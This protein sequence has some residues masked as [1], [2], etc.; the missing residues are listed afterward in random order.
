MSQ[1]PARK[2]RPAARPVSQA[3]ARP[4]NRARARP[5]TSRLV[6]ALLVLLA[7]AGLYGIAGLNRA[8]EATAVR[9]AGAVGQ[10]AVT[11]ALLGCPG[12]GSGPVTGGSFAEASAPASTGSGHVTLTVPVPSAEGQLA[13]PAVTTPQ[14]G[15]LTVKAIKTAPAQPKKAA[16]LP[17]MAGGRV[18]T[19]RAAGGVFVSAAGANAQG[20]DV[21][22]LGGGG[23]PTA[24]CQAPGSDFWFVGPE[25]TTTQTQ[26]YLMNPDGAPA[27]ARVDV[28]TDSGP[29]L[30]TPDSGILVPPHEMIVQNLDRLVHAARAVALHV[31]TTSG[32]VVAALRETDK[33]SRPGIWLPA[34][35]D[36]AT[37]QVLTGLPDV[38]GTRK[39]YITVPGSKAAKISVTAVSPRGSYQ[40]TGG[41]GINLLGKLTTSVSIP[42]LSGFPG[43]IKITSNVPVTAVL[44]VSGGPSGAPGAF[45]TASGPITEQGVVAASPVGPAGTTDLVLSAPGQAASVRIAH[46]VPGQALTGQQGRVVHIGAK[47]ATMV[48]IKLPK[49]EAHAPVV[50]LLITP[51]PGSGPVYAAR[52]A[53]SRGAVQDVLPVLSAPTRITLPPARQSLVAVLGN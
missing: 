52:I 5:L 50:A 46:A 8:V 33:L 32:R 48:A 9:P 20:F 21:E 43:S 7:L 29:L 28:Q 13:P 38:T 22:Q 34:A 4:V 30:G 25:A 16:T 27:D 45:V 18:P 31:T 10:L 44:E 35:A 36:P 42:A 6:V 51:E 15:Q 47:S 23:R 17:T 39:L 1:R 40:P 53:K 12:P 19:S 3:R 49:R 41:N 14:P 26:L 2:A 37:S 24:R 11:S